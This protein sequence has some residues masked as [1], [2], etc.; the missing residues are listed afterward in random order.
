MRESLTIYG[1]GQ[2]TS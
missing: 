1:A 2:S